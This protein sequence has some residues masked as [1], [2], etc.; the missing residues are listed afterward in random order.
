MS[1]KT[2]IEPATARLNTPSP[3]RLYVYALSDRCRLS[4]TAFGPITGTVDG[5]AKSGKGGA[6]RN[7]GQPGRAIGPVYRIRLNGGEVF[8]RP[9][10]ARARA[11]W[12]IIPGCAYSSERHC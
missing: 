9:Q 2:V 11:S 7:Q 1:A 12:G 4:L 3:G 10:N 5:N 8:F 6:V